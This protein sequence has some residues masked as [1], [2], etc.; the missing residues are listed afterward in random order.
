MSIEE[1]LAEIPKLSRHDA[2]LVRR[3][4]RERVSETPP[5]QELDGHLFDDCADEVSSDLSTNPN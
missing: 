1:I 2:G 3:A 4:L 5:A